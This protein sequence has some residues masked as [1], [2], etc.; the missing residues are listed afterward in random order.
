MARLEDDLEE[1][2]RNDPS[3]ELVA[4]MRE[5][6]RD[7]EAAT[8][9]VLQELTHGELVEAIRND[10]NA[11]V[12]PALRNDPAAVQ[13]VLD[14]LDQAQREE[15]LRLGVEKDR[16]RRRKLGIKGNYPELSSFIAFVG[17]SRSGGS[18]VAALLDAHP[19]LVVAHELP[20]FVPDEIGEPTDELKYE[21]GYALIK[22]LLRWARRDARQGRKGQRVDANGNIYYS[23]YE[24][25]DGW[26]GR[27]DVLMAAGTKNAVESTFAAKSFGGAPF[28]A[29]SEQVGLP[30]RFIHV[31]RNPYDN[32]A[33]MARIH[34]D[35]AL[36]RYEK[37]LQGVRRLKDAGFDIL[38]IH[39]D[40]VVEDPRRE[41]LRMCEFFGVP[42]YEDHLDGCAKAVADR[43]SRSG[44]GVEWSESDRRHVKRLIGTYEWLARYP[45]LEV[46]AP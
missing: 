18:I 45:I 41:V 30:L 8:R 4:A 43:P 42:T 32:I 28:H 34:G 46:G 16:E 1:A 21:D 31:I 7:D 5:A 9:A 40:D 33:T 14:E 26:Q 12:V 19:N 15:I 37:R 10:P 29:L 35:R 3:P 27:Y 24:V 6:F 25:T 44:A 39:L 38:D 36:V 23:S 13:A 11:D 20:V 17:Y 2:L 22:H